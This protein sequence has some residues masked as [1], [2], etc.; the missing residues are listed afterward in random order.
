MNARSLFRYGLAVFVL[1][2]IPVPAPAQA[3]DAMDISGFLDGIGHWQRA[4]GRDRDDARYDPSQIVE[5]ADNLLAHQHQDGGW[6]KDIDWLAIIDP[7]VVRK[8]Q[9]KNYARSTFD[10][11]NT[12][13]QIDYLARVYEATGHNRFRDAAARGLEH[14]LA[15]QRPS[16]GWRGWDVDAIT[17]NDDVMTGVMALLRDIRYGDSHFQWID[18]DRRSRLS[19]SLDR[20]IA[21][22]LACQIVVDGVRTGWCQQ[23]GHESLAPVQARTYELPSIGGSETVAVVYFLMS[24]RDPAPEIVD[25]VESAVAWLESARIEGI[26]MERFDIPPQRFKSYTAT[27]DLRIVEDPNAPTLWA[28]F[29]DLETGQPFFCNRD[30]NKVD[31]LAD[32]EL[33]RRSGYAWYGAWATQLL[34]TDYPAWRRKR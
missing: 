30:G 25:A 32:V 2:Q 10:N 12:Y 9:G 15:E 3:Y 19:E 1:I 29:Y 14:I 28:R 21:V 13:S 4:Y 7:G 16:G 34:E 8:L 27:H 23:H 24:L 6:P 31:R 11:R 17:Y 5:I 26:R 22:T 33:E 18:D 20:A